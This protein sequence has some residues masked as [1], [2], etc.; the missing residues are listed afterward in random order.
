MAPYR[1]SFGR[2]APK[3]NPETGITAVVCSQTAL[4]Q[5]LVS[6]TLLFVALGGALSGITGNYLGRRGTM[7]VGALFAAIGA[8]GMLG[9]AGNF[10][11]YLACKCIGGVGLGHIIAAAVVYGAECTI[12]SKRGMLLALYNVGLGFGNAAAAA[13][14][15]GSSS[16]THSNLAWQIPIICQIPLSFILGFGACCFP[17]SP[18]WLL[19]KGRE[20]AAKRSF[21]WFYAK[22]A[23]HPDVLLQV[24]DVQRHIDMERLYGSTTSWTETFRGQNVR[25]TA[26]SSLIMV[27]LAITG[28]KFVGPYGAI[29]LAKVGIKNVFLNNFLAAACTMAGTIPGPLVVEYGGRR[30][31]M[32]SGYTTMTICMLIIAV[33]GSTLGQAS[34]AAKVVL[35][36]FLFLWAF[37]FGMFIGTS[38]WIAAPEQHNIRLRTYGQASTTTV[39][40]IFGFAASFYGPYM[41]SADYGN[42]GLNVGYFYA[43]KSVTVLYCAWTRDIVHS[44]SLLTLADP[45]SRS[46]LRYASLDLLVRPGNGE[47][48]PRADRRV[49]LLWQARVE[50]LHA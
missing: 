28:S 23:D 46:D 39:Y 10:T 44:T 22:P 18:R 29:F 33:V 49:L 30:F 37:L 21:A 45:R 20:E 17:E 7:Q 16:Y 34:N 41:L 26:V 25:R 9:T 27:G 8:G 32:L 14:C 1:K 12:A 31:S 2:C 36:V 40:Q 38:V 15:W 35:L 50:D 11:A 42:M 24:Q 6:L 3:T 13:V 4:Q 19:T 47:T 5:G 48:H 43:G